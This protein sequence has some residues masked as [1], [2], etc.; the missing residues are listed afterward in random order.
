MDRDLPTKKAKFDGGYASTMQGAEA[1][2]NKPSP[3]QKAAQEKEA[4]AASASAATSA[5]AA[6]AAA[7][8]GSSSVD[9]SIVDAVDSAEIA[10]E[11]TGT[12]IEVGG[13][14]QRGVHCI[15]RML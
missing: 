5:A 10:A 3:F 4:A 7:A 6:A 12:V 15:Y 1:F 13:T 9:A 11:M 8:G 14:A 2:F